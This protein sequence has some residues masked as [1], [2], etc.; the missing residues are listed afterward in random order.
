MEEVTYK[1]EVGQCPATYNFYVEHRKII[2][3]ICPMCETMSGFIPTKDYDEETG[4]EMNHFAPVNK[5]LFAHFKN[6]SRKKRKTKAAIK[7]SKSTKKGIRQRKVKSITLDD[8]MG[9][10]VYRLP[11]TVAKALDKLDLK[12]ITNE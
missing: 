6:P 5:E 8:V 4:F 11:Y 3:L 2:F 1:H 10:S 9:K 12:T 7:G